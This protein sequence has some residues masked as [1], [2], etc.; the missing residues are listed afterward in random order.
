[1]QPQNQLPD[2]G[3]EKQLFGGRAVDRS[4]RDHR[5]SVGH[6]I[7]YPTQY[8]RLTFLQFGSLFLP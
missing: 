7:S 2:L 6:G 5:V 4:L 8:C 1:M 3:R